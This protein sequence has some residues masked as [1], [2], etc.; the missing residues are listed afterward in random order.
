MP[1][2]IIETRTLPYADFKEH[3]RVDASSIEK[4]ALIA[5]ARIQEPLQVGSKA[6]AMRDY[7][8]IDGTGKRHGQQACYFNQVVN[9]V[10]IRVFVVPTKE[11]G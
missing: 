9:G 1:T 10:K 11:G 7:E 5:N 6:K 3:S 4:A 8:V 2:Y